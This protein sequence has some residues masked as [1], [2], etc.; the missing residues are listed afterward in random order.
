MPVGIAPPGPWPTVRLSRGPAVGSRWR[1]F[2][3]LSNRGHVSVTSVGTLLAVTRS[4]DLVICPLC[5]Q[6][7][8]FDGPAG[9]IV[10]LVADHAS[11]VEVDWLL[12]QVDMAKRR[13]R[14]REA[15][16]ILRPV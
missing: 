14:A 12:A 11:L 6:P 2:A 3:Q 15:I 13:S 4:L 1:L 7:F 16:S 9:V 5:S 10:H 8:E